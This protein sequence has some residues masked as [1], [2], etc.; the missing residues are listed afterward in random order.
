MLSV[1]LILDF[2]RHGIEIRADVR[3]LFPSR[4]RQNF[5]EPLGHDE[6]HFSPL[7]AE[8]NPICHFWHY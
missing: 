7:N 6:K 4:D 1:I 5:S 2:K 8:L 3:R